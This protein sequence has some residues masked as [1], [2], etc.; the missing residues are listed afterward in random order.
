MD[1]CWI[2]I[3]RNFAPLRC[4]WN[5]PQQESNYVVLILPEV[6][7]V[8]TW[9]RRVVDRLALGGVPSLA[10]PL[11]ARTAPELDLGYSEKELV[12]GRRYKELTTTNEIFDDIS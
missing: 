5:D 12:E 10:M 8:N 2:V 7:G 11:F 1:G 3:N 9:V 4:W 6:F